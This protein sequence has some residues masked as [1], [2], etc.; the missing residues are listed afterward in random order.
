MDANYSWDASNNDNRDASNSSK[1]IS[2]RKVGHQQQ[3]RQGITNANSSKAAC[4]SSDAPSIEGMPAT[5]VT[6]QEQGWQQLVRFRGI[7]D[8]IVQMANIR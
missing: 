7:R 2:N 1:N 8:Q 4:Y 5:P 6:Q 3:R